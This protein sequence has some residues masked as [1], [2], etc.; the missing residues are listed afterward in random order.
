MTGTS[1]GK[2]RTRLTGTLLLFNLSTMMDNRLFTMSEFVTEGQ[3]DD[4]QHH[5]ERCIENNREKSSFPQMSRFGTT[6]EELDD[7]LF[8]YQAILDSQ[9]TERSRYTMAGLIIMIP[10]VVLAFLYP[11]NEMPL[12]EWTLPLAVLVGVGLW[13][14]AVGLKKLI[15][16]SRINR[17]NKQHPM[18]RDY[19]R[20]VLEYTK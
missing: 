17:L 3:L 9:G 13:L 1:F 11:V 2:N 6:Q 14:I 7:Y 10:V 15:M 4:F 5:V 16:K 12:G 18:A 19:V 20:A 8:D